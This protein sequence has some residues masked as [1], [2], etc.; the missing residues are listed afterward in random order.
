MRDLPVQGFCVY[1]GMPGLTVEAID[2]HST[3]LLLGWDYIEGLAKA[4]Q[5]ERGATPRDHKF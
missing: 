4:V 2:Y 1:W 3:E 5:E